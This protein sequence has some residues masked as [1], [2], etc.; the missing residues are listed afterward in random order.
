MSDLYFTETGD[1]LIDG[2]RD[3]AIT[4]NNLRNDVQQVYLRLMTEPGDFYIYPQLGLDISRLYGMPQSPET[5][6]IGKRMIKAALDRENIF[7]GKDIRIQAI[8]TGPSVIRFDVHIVSSTDQPVVISIDQR[9][10]D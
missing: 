2:N 7:A 3:I 10:G 4:Q 8:P 1:I 6:E 9:L 5:G